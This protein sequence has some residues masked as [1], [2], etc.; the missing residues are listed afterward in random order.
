MPHRAA[1]LMTKGIVT[2]RKGTLLP[3]KTHIRGQLLSILWAEVF[4]FKWFVVSAL[5]FPL[6]SLFFPCFL[7]FL[8]SFFPLF[9]LFSCFLVLFLFSGAQKSFLASTASRF[10]FYIFFKKKSVFAPII[11]MVVTN[12][13]SVGYH[14]VIGD[15]QVE[16]RYGGSSQ[17]FIAESPDECARAAMGVTHQS[18][19]LLFS[20]TL[21][22]LPSLLSD[23][24]NDHLLG[25]F[26]LYKQLTY[27]ECQS[28]QALAHSLVANCS[29]HAERICIGV[30]WCVLCV[31]C[32]ATLQR[33]SWL[34][35]SF[36]RAC[37]KFSP[38]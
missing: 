32:A 33:D 6:F 7:V 15:D 23:H 11:I 8:F 3:R 36:T 10:L 12:W 35:L 29:L 28:A 13:L 2:S 18:G 30:V 5:F 20:L 31:V 25:R 1:L 19:L 26:S 21:L 27:P 17:T 14:L 34:I 37:L 9:S 16:S 4:I 24:D 38:R 22:F